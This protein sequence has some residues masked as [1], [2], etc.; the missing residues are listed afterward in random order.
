ML[1]HIVTDAYSCVLHFRVV[2]NDPLLTSH[3]ESE[4]LRVRWDREE[5]RVYQD[6]L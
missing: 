2:T 3:R 1:V 4:V 6:Y 5:D